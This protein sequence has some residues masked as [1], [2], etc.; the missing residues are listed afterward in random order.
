MSVDRRRLQDG[1]YEAGHCEPIGVTT[2]EPPHRATQVVAEVIKDIIPTAPDQWYSFKQ[3][4]PSSQ[5]EKDELAR[6]TTETVHS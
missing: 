3:I 6:L 4:W 5:A 2:A 1:T